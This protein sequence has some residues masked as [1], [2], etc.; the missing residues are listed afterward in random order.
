M[1]SISIT[2]TPKY[3]VNFATEYKFTTCG[4]CI[5][6]KTGRKIK[7]VYNNGSIGYSIRGKFYSLTRL[8]NHLE[9]PKE[10][11]APF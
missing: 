7:K 11:E 2:Y 1:N 5:N 9:K 3:Q 8:R 10:V 4:L 6:V